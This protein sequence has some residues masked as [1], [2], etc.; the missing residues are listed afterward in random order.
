MLKRKHQVLFR[1]N[2]TEYKVLKRNVKRSGLNREE[3]IRSALSNVTFKEL[4]SLEF[5]DI[6]KNLRQ[7][8]N[9]LNQIAIKANAYGFIDARAYREN[10]SKLQEQIG[11]IIRGIY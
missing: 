5:Y 2:D 10:Y 1:L 6:L 7:I 9:N 8:N 3:Y 4:P 11:E